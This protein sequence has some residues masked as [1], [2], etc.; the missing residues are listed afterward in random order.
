M[1]I[2]RSI[3]ISTHIPIII[4]IMCATCIVSP[5]FVD[6]RLSSD[7]IETHSTSYRPTIVF[8]FNI[9]WA[10]NSIGYWISD[11]YYHFGSHCWIFCFQFS[12]LSSIIAYLI[13]NCC[14]LWLTQ[15]NAQLSYSSQCTFYVASSNEIDRD[16]DLWNENK[17]FRSFSSRLPS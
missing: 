6:V 12:I 13:K 1:E 14:Q 17:S 11:I 8:N 3:F 9:L 2:N 5:F 10:I 16:I 7:S 4:N 15:T